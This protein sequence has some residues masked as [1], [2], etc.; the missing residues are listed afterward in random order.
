MGLSDS[1]GDGHQGGR[2][3][4]SGTAQEMEGGSS[5]E[6]P[7]PA[8]QARESAEKSVLQCLGGRGVWA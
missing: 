5:E 6:G 7:V 3:R 8:A 2:T 1:S 4:S